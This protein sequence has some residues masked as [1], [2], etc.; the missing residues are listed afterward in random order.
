MRG[1]A[2]RNV[3]HWGEYGDLKRL[4]V[5]QIPIQDLLVPMYTTKKIKRE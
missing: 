1:R 2:L 5:P 4:I 3:Y